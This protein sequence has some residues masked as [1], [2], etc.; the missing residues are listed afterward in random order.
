M[1]LL[2]A[3]LAVGVLITGSSP[4]RGVAETAPALRAEADSLSRSESAALLELYAAASSLTRAQ[5]DLSRLEERSAQLADTEQGVRRRTEIVRR[6]LSASQE[7]V[8]TLLRDLYIEGEPDPMSVILGATSLDE[9]V[10]GIE[11]LSRATAMNQRLG[12]EAEQRARQL[13]RLSARLARQR[14]GLDSSRSA[15]RQSAERLAMAVAGRRQTIAAIRREHSLTTQRLAALQS[16]A[17]AAARRSAEITA[18]SAQPADA[19]SGT[20]TSSGATASSPAAPDGVTAATA[21]PTTSPPA[22]ASSGARTLV[23]DVVAYHLPGKTASGLPVGIGV[24]AVD[25]TV[26]PLGTRVFVPGYGPAVAADV[27]S[28][29]KGN[30]IDLW[31]PTTA[32]ARA[33]G[34]R[35]VTITI[36]G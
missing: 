1:S 31:M 15:A 14:A 27:G 35:T 22:S 7:R 13:G 20:E 24:I 19:S 30:I 36:Y 8:A 29:V 4:S 17:R 21:A 6:S 12:N 23:A 3:A 25:P 32:Q 34:R 2:S 5:V 18:S 9:A 26:I 11:E 16:R 10:A 28:A 33:W